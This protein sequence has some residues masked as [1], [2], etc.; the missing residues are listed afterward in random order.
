MPGSLDPYRRVAA[1]LAGSPARWADLRISEDVL[2]AICSAEDLCALFFHRISCSGA[3]EDWPV[4]VTTALGDMARRQA[5]EELLR[6]AEIASVVEALTEAGITPVLIKGTPLAYSVYDHPSLRS[7]SD[8]DVLIAESDVDASRRVMSALGYSPA[9]HCSDLFSQ[10]E[11]Q[12]QDRF[13]VCHAFDVHWKISTQ[14]MFVHVLTHAA[15]LPRTIPVPALGRHARTL[16][17]V[18]ALLLACVHPVMHH[19][20][21]PRVLWLYDI[22]LLAAQLS[23]EEW[24]TFA[25]AA[26]HN[27]IA[28][29]CGHQLALTRALFGTSLPS[30]TLAELSDVPNEST[31]EYLA[32]GRTWRHELVASLRSLPSTAT[33]ARMLRQVLLPAPAYMLAAYG[34]QDRRYGRWFLPALY[35]HRNLRGAWRIVS[36]RK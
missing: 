35:V 5:A 9:V 34:L 3:K 16:G 36:G 1:F 10:F 13:G 27:G 25:R 19:R 18:D 2:L 26:L 4:S 22:H 14:P 33:R 24:S 23:R 6:G 17:S 7:R 28:N 31:S 15:A 20:G 12:K 30:A 29:V 8:T 11:M 21:E 32:S